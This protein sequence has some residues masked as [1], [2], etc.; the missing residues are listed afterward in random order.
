MPLKKG[1]SLLNEFLC[2]TKGG[3]HCK[4]TEQGRGRMMKRWNGATT[5]WG[6]ATASVLFK[7]LV[8]TYGCTVLLFLRKHTISEFFTHIFLRIYQA[9]KP[10]I[11]SPSV[12]GACWQPSSTKN[13]SRFLLAWKRGIHFFSHEHPPVYATLFIIYY[14]HIFHYILY[15]KGLHMT[16]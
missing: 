10:T 2:S 6:A 8:N 14:I 5:E 3:G 12:N 1:N 9:I 13:S 15:T 7:N 4:E 16:N 11:N